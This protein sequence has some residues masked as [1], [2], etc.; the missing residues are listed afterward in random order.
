MA[1]EQALCRGTVAPAFELFRAAQAVTEGGARDIFEEEWMQPLFE[2]LNEEMDAVMRDRNTRSPA[3][4]RWLKTLRSVL[5][6]E[7]KNLRSVEIKLMQTLPK[8]TRAAQEACL[9]NAFEDQLELVKEHGQ[10]LD[11]AAELIGI[12][13][14]GRACTVIEG[15][16]SGIREVIVENPPGN[17]R[18]FSLVSAALKVEDYKIVCYGCARTF[19]QILGLNEAAALLEASYQDEALLHAKLEYL[20][21]FVRPDD[22]EYLQ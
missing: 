3:T 5:V 20:G 9:G 12:S 7:I 6:E 19:A 16:V 15:F 21:E 2:V 1:E 10:R 18:D 11:E 4:G 13:A 17:A 14:K 8:M 22:G